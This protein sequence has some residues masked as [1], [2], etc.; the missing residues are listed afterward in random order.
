MSDWRSMEADQNLRMANKML[1][2]QGEIND[3]KA[4]LARLRAHHDEERNELRD[5]IDRLRAE[6]AKAG[7]VIEAITDVVKN[8][9]GTDV[10]DRLKTYKADHDWYR[11][12]FD[13]AIEQ[14]NAAER[15]AE[16]YRAVVEAVEV[17]RAKVAAIRGQEDIGLLTREIGLLKAVDALGAAGEQTAGGTFEAM[18]ADPDGQF[19]PGGEMLRSVVEYM[20]APAATVSSVPRTPPSA[21]ITGDGTAIAVPHACDHWAHTVNIPR[22]SSI[23]WAVGAYEEYQA[24]MAACSAASR[25][26]AGEEVAG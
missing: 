25:A 17:W 7:E 6:L 8:A 5:E 13:K 26:Q 16:T 9:D 19:D 12:A 23:S 3:L 11:E 18:L 10:L 1:E 4:E 14:R 21:R 22:G 2:Q 15:M 24:H 20:N